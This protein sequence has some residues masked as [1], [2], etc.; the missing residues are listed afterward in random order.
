MI[1]VRQSIRK[2]LSSRSPLQCSQCSRLIHSSSQQS[3]RSKPRTS[4][5]KSFNQSFN[6]P[7]NRFVSSL[8]APQTTLSYLSSYNQLIRTRRYRDIATLYFIQHDEAQ[9]DPQCAIDQSIVKVVMRA[10]IDGKDQRCVELIDHITQLNIPVDSELLTLMLKACEFTA[11]GQRAEQ[12]ISQSADQSIQ[13]ND[14][15]HASVARAYI[16]AKQTARAAEYIEKFNIQ[17]INPSLSQPLTLYFVQTNKLSSALSLI[18]QTKPVDRTVALKVFRSAIEQ[19]EKSTDPSLSDHTTHQSLDSSII[20]RAF[21][22]VALDRSKPIHAAALH[23][24]TKYAIKQSDNAFIDDILTAAS[25]SRTDLDDESINNLIEYFSTAKRVDLALSFISK[26]AMFRWTH[27]KESLSLSSSKQTQSAES[28]ASQRSYEIKS[29][30]VDQF[31]RLFGSDPVQLE[32]AVQWLTEHHM[33]SSQ[34]QLPVFL[35]DLVLLSYVSNSSIANKNAVDLFN[36]FQSIHSFE[37][38]GFTMRALLLSSIRAESNQSI[39][40]CMHAI[41]DSSTILIDLPLLTLISA[42]YLQ[43]HHLDILTDMLTE[44]ATALTNKATDLDFSILMSASRFFFETHIELVDAVISQLEQMNFSPH[45][46]LSL[47]AVAGHVAAQDDVQSYDSINMDDLELVELDKPVER[48][49][50]FQL[51]FGRKDKSKPSGTLNIDEP[52]EKM[53]MIPVEQWQSWGIA[54]TISRAVRDMWE[55]RHR[56]HLDDDEET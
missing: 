1:S 7:S 19:W 27:T 28:R 16:N 30:T 43:R 5:I 50:F 45:M 4:A 35:F 12:L 42:V 2:T 26:Q 10:M 33:R 48:K 40:K 25:D 31:V 14:E 24:A 15:H 44:C 32:Q 23:A 36:H 8:N 56:R 41:H 49:S 20:R 21:N 46:Q 17:S 22:L 29:R 9:R 52:V 53:R 51:L 18:E 38:S 37:P 6:R 39:N 47:R 55:R 11:D 13:L 34:S 54:T 3:T